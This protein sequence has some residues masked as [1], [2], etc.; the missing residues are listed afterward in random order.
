MSLFFSSCLS[1]DSAWW[2]DGLFFLFSPVRFRWFLI[3]FY[4]GFKEESF[5]N[6][7]DWNAYTSKAQNCRNTFLHTP[8][9][10]H[11]AQHNTKNTH[12]CNGSFIASRQ[13]CAESRNGKEI[14]VR[15]HRKVWH[16]QRTQM[17]HEFIRD[18][19][20]HIQ[21]ESLRLKSVQWVHIRHMAT[22][23]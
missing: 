1:F 11:T 5:P 21:W 9:A 3:T 17:L 12:K 4:V 14:Y 19:D 15:K 6:T 20:K 22:A 13:W 23:D 7:Q 18:S 8:N 16:C 2:N 10:E